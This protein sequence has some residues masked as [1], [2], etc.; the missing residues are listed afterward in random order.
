MND[1]GLNALIAFFCFH[2]EIHYSLIGV[3]DSINEALCHCDAACARIKCIGT[4][5]GLGFD[6]DLLI[7]IMLEMT[8]VSN[9]AWSWVFLFMTVANTASLINCVYRESDTTSPFPTK[10]SGPGLAK[11]A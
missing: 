1:E 11:A 6:M 9:D 4:S 3:H 8:S 7:T 5:R 2:F 10:K